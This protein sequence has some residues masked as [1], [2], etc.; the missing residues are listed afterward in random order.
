M[1]PDLVKGAPKPRGPGPEVKLHSDRPEG[2]LDLWAKA[3]L[4]G[5]GAT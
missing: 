4:E 2:P 3:P 1:G 5:A